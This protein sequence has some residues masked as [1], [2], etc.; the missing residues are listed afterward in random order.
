[1]P[2]ARGALEGF[3]CQIIMWTL[4]PILETYTGLK[5]KKFMLTPVLEKTSSPVRMG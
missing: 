4:V 1:M 2:E 5:G 3:L